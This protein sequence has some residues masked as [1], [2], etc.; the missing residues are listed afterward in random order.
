MVNELTKLKKN[1][2]PNK[3]ATALSV[4]VTKYRLCD[5][6]PIFDVRNINRFS[7]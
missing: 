7:Y 6:V 2:N 5:S 4:A 3:K 1:V